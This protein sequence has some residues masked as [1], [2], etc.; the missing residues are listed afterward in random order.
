MHGRARYHAAWACAWTLYAARLL[1]ISIFLVTRHPAWLF[2]HQA[3]TGLTALFLLWAA[4]LFSRDPLTIALAV[5]ATALMLSS[6]IPA[7][8]T[9]NRNP[10]WSLTLPLAARIRRAPV[11]LGIQLSHAPGS[12]MPS[13]AGGSTAPSRAKTARRDSR[14]SSRSS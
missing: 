7:L 8:R 12:R 4:L 10:L 11:P 13:M 1:L 5:A 6:Y 14:S 3:V 2:A 9:Y